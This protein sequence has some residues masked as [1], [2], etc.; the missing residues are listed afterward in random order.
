VSVLRSQDSRRA[1]SSARAQFRARRWRALRENRF[2]WL[3][4][5][6]IGLGS[7]VALAFTEGVPQLIF[8]GL[9]GATIALVG[10]GWLIGG[11]VYSLPWLWG[12]IGER[13]TAEALESLGDSWASEHDLPRKRGNWDHVLA[14]PA[15]IFLLDTKRLTQRAVA[16][17]DALLAGRLRNDGGGF[18][19]AAASLGEELEPMCGRRPW[20]QAVVV[21][22]GEFPQRRHEEN[23]VTYVHGDE[24]VGWLNEQPPRLSSTFVRTVAGALRELRNDRPSPK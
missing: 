19:A 1:G 24:L 13:Q 3:R 23:R 20:V 11:D 18:R 15:G 8:A 6:L 10:F 9:L 12:S 2:D 5:L 17:G 7:I 22:W 16:A 21:I 4:I 14:G